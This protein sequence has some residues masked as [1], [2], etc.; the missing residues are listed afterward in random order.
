MYF[1]YDDYKAYCYEAPLMFA[2]GV[3]I[4][5]LYHGVWLVYMVWTGKRSWKKNGLH[6]LLLA[7]LSGSVCITIGYLLNGG[8]YLRDEKETYAVEIQG[9]IS[10]IKGLGDLDFPVVKGDYLYEEK[11]G[12]EFTIDGVR[13]KG[14]G[15]GSL[16][17]GD[18]VTV[19]YLPKSG[20]ILYIAETDRNTTDIE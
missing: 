1:N 20:Y 18:Y 8:M 7:A 19:K 11:N 2:I 3:S 15:I 13:C 16:E 17:V 5:V 14:V 6:L 10:D 9:E 12:Y 4:V